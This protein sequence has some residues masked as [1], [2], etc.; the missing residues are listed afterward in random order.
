MNKVIDLINSKTD[1]IYNACIEIRRHIHKNPELSFYE[2]ETENYICEWLDK[3]GI[4]YK[5]DIAKTGVVAVINGN[6]P[7]KTLLIRADMDA[8]PIDEKSDKLYKS[9]NFGVMHACGHDV[10]TTILLGTAYV[11]NSIKEEFS[12][13]VKLVFQPGEE[14]TGGALPMINEGILENPTVDVCLALHCDP[15][16]KC[17]TVRI[18]EGA[19]YASPDEFTLKIIG[20]GGHAAKPQNC[21]NPITVT[22]E[23]VLQLNEF[24]HN[25]VNSKDIGVLTIAS[26]NS[27]TATNIIPDT[28][29]IT[30]TARAFDCET[31]KFLKENI[32]KISNSVCEK[33]GADIEYEF[34]EMFPPLINDKDLSALVFKLSSQ[35][36]GDNNCIFGGDKTM[37][38]EDFAYFSE[39]KP[40]VMIKLGCQSEES[41]IVNKL[42]NCSFDVKEDCIKSGIKVFAFFATNYC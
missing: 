29:E 33:F 24:A 28:A 20:K 25:Y 21:I 10:H 13:C 32:G 2:Y 6:N 9:S 31:R 3:W 30:G 27:G 26:Y 41:G 39:R 1:E 12:G 22:S 18:K 40:S 8:L 34:R 5:K 19:L 16:L 35:I 37:E 4:E 14:T 42:H 36:L 17:G 15:D 23:L 7:G 11:L 38:G